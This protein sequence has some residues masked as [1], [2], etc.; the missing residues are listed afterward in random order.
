VTAF[1][2]KQFA[3]VLGITPQAVRKYLCRL[4]P[5]GALVVNGQEAAAWTVARLPESL[6]QRLEAEAARQHCRNVETLLA[7]PRQRYKPEIPLEKICDADIHAANKLREALRPWLIRQH[8]LTL[9]SSEMEAQGVEDYRR[10]FGT[11]ITARYWREL[12]A[13][14]IQRDNGFE[15]WNRLEIYLPTRLTPK[16]LPQEIVS[17][18]L[19]DDFSELE[20]YLAECVNPHDPSEPEREGFWRLI[21]DKLAAL[22]RAGT[23]EKAASRR[24]RQFLFARAKFIAPT[25]NALRMA[26]E[27]RLAK[28]VPLN[29]QSLAD[30]RTDNG[31]VAEY[32]LVDIKRVRH[33][34]VLKNG[35]RIDVAWREEYQRLSEYT[36]SRHPESIKCPRAFYDRVN[37]EK[38][39]ALFARM[40]GKRTLRKMI[41]GIT[42]NAEGIHTMARWVVDD[43]TSNIEVLF[44][45]Q[46]G[47]VSLIQ[48]QIIAVMDFAS[49][50]WVG[51]AVSNDK[52]PTAEL[53]CAAI[54]DGFRRHNVPRKLFVE[55]GFVFGKSL[56]VNG[57][58]DDEGR[59]I[60][61]GLSQY[62]CSIHHFDKMSPTSKGELEKSF[63][64]F[65]RRM[66]RHPGYT[67]RLQILDASEDFKREQ[68]LIRSGKMDG[69]KFRYTFEEFIRVMCQLIDGY[70]A[71]PQHGHL[72]G[73]SPNE[74]F[75]AM[76]DPTDPPI[77]FDNRILWILANERYRVS[78]TAGGVS[79]RHYGRKIQ[80]R[81][82]TLPQHV[83]EELWAL[84][85][86]QDDSMVTF[87]SMDYRNTFTVE[88][89]RQPSADETR[90]ASGSSVLASELK[91]IG[92]HMRATDDELKVLKTEFG[93]PRND[94]LAAIRGESNALSSVPGDTRRVILNSRIEA[95]A[96]QMQAQRQAI[97]AKKLQNTA[98]K[99]KARRM[100]IPAVLVDDD[101]QSRRA[102]ELLGDAASSNPADGDGVVYHLKPSAH[103][104]VEYVDYL[105]AQLAKFRKAGTGF[106]QKFPGEITFASVKKITTVQLDCDPHDVSRFDEVCAHL[107]AKI[108]ATILGKSNRSKSI[109]NYHEFSK[110]EETPHE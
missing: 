38:V 83:G 46:D 45:S 1:T 19:A 110:N 103:D 10:A 47:T 29:P 22:V 86:R 64:L 28:W 60:V 20:D 61:A 109:A 2:A 65:Q 87:M 77:K 90:M 52:A 102:L 34:A 23:S 75:E 67:G 53:V 59:T 81:G 44:T 96:E 68:R 82:G 66:E 79:F 62:G 14:T 48:P 18:A 35:G 71:E 7:L 89:C 42:R 6:R 30:G 33:S 5:D 74:A 80:A 54:L 97:T 91:K 57:R 72:N 101:D 85:D 100:G 11:T 108:D 58:T 84:V 24:I 55:N 94:L 16:V 31:D 99:S 12:F 41:G 76:T 25:R 70:N 50:K 17:R 13:R 21:L 105:I 69:K 95:S 3:D 40:Q 9:A 92:A 73:L 15:E 98:N 32:P 37:R 63:D 93:N 39:D 51:W 26:L 78:V 49:R 106:G 43:M 88:T 4:S 56:N 36:R 8:D 107:K 27:R 104:Q